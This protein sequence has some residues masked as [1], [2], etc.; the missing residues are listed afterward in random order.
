V[1][2]G[3][4]T[5]YG[6]V[7]RSLSHG[8]YQGWDLHPAQL[9]TRYAAV[10]THFAGTAAADA[11]RLRSY[12]ERSGGAIADEPATAQALSRSFLRAVECGALTGD[13][14]AELTGL[15]TTN[16]RALARREPI[17]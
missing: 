17:S 11:G 13:E 2:G 16:L 14:V 7:R 6:L 8:F 12:L 10:Y 4:R 9:V 3:W 5:H 1:R 15:T